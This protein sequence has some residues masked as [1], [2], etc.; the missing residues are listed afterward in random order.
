MD[1]GALSAD[2]F[3]VEIV[4]KGRTEKVAEI[5]QAGYGQDIGPKMFWVGEHRLELHLTEG[6]FIMGP[7][8]FPGSYRIDFVVVY[9]SP[10]STPPSR[11]SP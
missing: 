10:P 4:A 1:Y 6:D 2:H 8:K 5:R 9:E 7:T 3:V 11:H